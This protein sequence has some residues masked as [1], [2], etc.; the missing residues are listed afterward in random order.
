M[1]E[2]VIVAAGLGS[3]VSAIS[4]GATDVYWSIENATQGGVAETSLATLSQPMPIVGGTNVASVVFSS[5]DTALYYTTLS[6]PMGLFQW[7]TTSP[8]V[9]TRY[10]TSVVA[11]ATGSVVAGGSPER[12]FFTALVSGNWIVYQVDPTAGTS[13][14]SPV[15]TC[16]S[17]TL[18]GPPLVHDGQAAYWYDGDGFQTASTTSTPKAINAPVMPLHQIAVDPAG[19]GDGLYWTEGHDLY[20]VP[21]TGSTTAV[22]LTGTIG[23]PAGLVS[24]GAYVYWIDAPP[25]CTGSAVWRIPNDGSGTANQMESVIP[26]C[27][28]N[29][30]QDATYLYYS[31]QSSTSVTIYRVP[32]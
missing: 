30:A 21:K 10:A 25:V 19:T 12:I 17:A 7:T 23:T 29:L 15:E 27:A 8:P 18:A 24:D 31:V 9:N 5:A 11:T 14:A 22:L 26:G 32:K 3:P 28:A 20:R 13:S 6:S 1:C 16:P 4:V 2:P